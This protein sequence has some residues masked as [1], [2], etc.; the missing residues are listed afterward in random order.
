MLLEY[1]HI[2]T[3]GASLTCNIAL[4]RANVALAAEVAGAH[5][6]VEA[7]LRAR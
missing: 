7:A 4:V 1:F 6:E 5:T 2:A 3:G